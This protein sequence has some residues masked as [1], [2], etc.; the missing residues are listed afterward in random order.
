MTKEKKMLLAID[1]GNTNIVAALFQENQVIHSWRIFSDTRRTGDEYESILRSL[2]R[3]AGV[4]PAHISGAVM[5]SVVPV[6]IGPFVGMIFQL[7]GQKP[8]IVGPQILPLLPIKVSESAVHQIGSDLVCNAVEA[9]C[10]FQGPCIIADFGTALTFTAIGKEGHIRGIAIAPGIGTAVTS[11]FENTAQLPSVPLEVPESVLGRNTTH[12]IQAGVILGYKGL[13]EF[14]IA[15]IK[16][17]LS[18]LEGL[19][20]ADIQVVATG[21]LNSVLAP[22]TNEFR[23]VDKQLTLAGLKRIFDILTDGAHGSMSGGAHV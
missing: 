5:S 2:L 23:Q 7:T 19:D 11:L 21:G 6:L 20:P 1:I 12:A 17:E 8:L 22:I 9:F 18:Q 15:Q 16:R 4:S 13:T 14:L 10:R 3:D